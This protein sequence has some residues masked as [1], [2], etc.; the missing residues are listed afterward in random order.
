MGPHEET[1][2]MVERIGMV[3]PLCEGCA[4]WCPAEQRVY[5]DLAKMRVKLDQ[6][7]VAHSH[8]PDRALIDLVAQCFAER[9]PEVG[10][11][12]IVQEVRN[13]RMSSSPGEIVPLSALFQ[14][15]K[16]QA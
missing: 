1:V 15:R 12:V 6:E 3:L 5:V 11:H 7:G 13:L 8:V 9:F 16:R 2:N 14:R 10:N 4:C